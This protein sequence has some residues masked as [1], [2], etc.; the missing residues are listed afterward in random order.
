[1]FTDAYYLKKM[2]VLH[3]LNIIRKFIIAFRALTMS[4]KGG[5]A[6]Y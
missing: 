5:N 3:N 6:R 4:S 1:M 2:Q